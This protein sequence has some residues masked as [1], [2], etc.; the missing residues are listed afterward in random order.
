MTY[1]GG[2]GEKSPPQHTN[3]HAR[4]NYTLSKQNS[5]RPEN[6]IF[7]ILFFIPKTKPE[8]HKSLTHH[9]G[10]NASMR[11][12][13]RTRFLLVDGS[14]PKSAGIPDKSPLNNCTQPTPAAT[15]VR[16]N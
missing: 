2:W 4:A 8:T 16:P 6:K 12:G 10:A 5:S 3:K 13:G 14:N 1:K 15:A 7:H 9:L 11:L